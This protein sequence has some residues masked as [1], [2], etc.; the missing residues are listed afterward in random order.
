MSTQQQHLVRSVATW[1]RL[2]GCRVG[3][4]T[5]WWRVSLPD[6]DLAVPP[7]V[8]MAQALHLVDSAYQR[9]TPPSLSLSP[10]KGEGAI[11]VP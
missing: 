3:M 2:C 8:R 1:I 10:S 6:V 9:T 4:A 5:G 7:E 11:A